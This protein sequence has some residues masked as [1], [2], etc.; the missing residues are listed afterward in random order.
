M[1]FTTVWHIHI[2]YHLKQRKLAKKSFDFEKVS[3]GIYHIKYVDN[4][5]FFEFP[6]RGHTIFGTDN[7]TLEHSISMLH[8]HR[9]LLN[10]SFI[11]LLLF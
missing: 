11:D 5:F 3:L 7:E 2:I 6:S 10:I 8:I 4:D 1:L 9:I